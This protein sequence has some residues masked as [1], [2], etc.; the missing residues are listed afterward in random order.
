MIAPLD[1]MNTLIPSLSSAADGLDFAGQMRQSRLLRT[2]KKH[3]FWLNACWAKAKYPP[4]SF[5]LDWTPCFGPRKTQD[6]GHQKSAWAYQGLSPRQREIE[7]LPDALFLRGSGITRANDFLRSTTISQFAHLA[8]VMRAN[9]QLGNL[10]QARRLVP[11]CLTGIKYAEF[12]EMKQWLTECLEDFYS[13]VFSQAPIA[14]AL[15]QSW[16][17]NVH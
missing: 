7:P 4:V 17:A 10:E 11:R 15:T 13:K 3:S 2:R 1:E 12:T 9:V 6:P 16:R 5:L 14:E 8:F